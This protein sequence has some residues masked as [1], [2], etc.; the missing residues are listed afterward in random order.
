M[1][2]LV[3]IIN[4]ISALVNIING[5]RGV[6]MAYI[7]PGG[8]FDLTVTIVYVI[9]STCVSAFLNWHIIMKLVHAFTL[10]QSN[11]C[12]DRDVAEYTIYTALIV[13]VMVIL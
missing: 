6:D 2:S 3:N 5:L 8:A 9:I 13:I 7:K 12:R 11:L 1:I 4:F 10:L